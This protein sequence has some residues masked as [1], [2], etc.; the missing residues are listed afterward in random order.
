KYFLFATA[1]RPDEELF[2][3]TIDPQC[4]NNLINND[5][6]KTERSRLSKVLTDYLIETE[7]PRLT[8]E[9]SPWDIFPYY[10]NN[11]KGITP[12]PNTQNE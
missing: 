3:I 4:Q 12:F 1:K 9:S 8:T 11:P 7:D 2:D 10:F 6:Y 5:D